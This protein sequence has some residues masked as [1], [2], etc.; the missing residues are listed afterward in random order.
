[1]QSLNHSFGKL[2]ANL[3]FAGISLYLRPSVAAIHSPNF[4][5]CYINTIYFMPFR[6]LYK[7]INNYVHSHQ[8]W[9]PCLLWKISILFLHCT[10]DSVSPWGS[11]FHYFKILQCGSSHKQSYRASRS[12]FPEQSFPAMP[13]PPTTTEIVIPDALQELDNNSEKMLNTTTKNLLA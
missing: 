5:V 3:Y 4:H 7:Y 11:Q 2:S 6:I 8:Q 10:Q 13:T 12:L 9:I 1:M